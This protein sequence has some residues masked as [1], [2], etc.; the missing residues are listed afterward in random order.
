[1]IRILSSR[2]ADRLLTRRVARMGE[3]ERTV[4]PILEAVRKRGDRALME[5]ARKLDGLQRKWIRISE[6][7]LAQAADRLAPKFRSA[8]KIAA[9]NVRRFAEK[10]LPREWSTMLSPGLRVGQLVR[11]LDAV[12]AYIPAG[13]YPLASTVIMTCIPALV[14]GVKSISIACPKP[15]DEVLGTAH[16]LGIENVFQMGGAQA[17]A[18][19]A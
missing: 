3:A 19:F 4:G 12:A 8:V 2:D 15:V 6:Q 10:Q 17:I 16:M 5:Y 18:A 9:K 13:R 11:P 7:E 1:M 14:A